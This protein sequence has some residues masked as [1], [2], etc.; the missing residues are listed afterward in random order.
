MPL[1]IDLAYS[2]SAV[3]GV[4]P[5]WLLAGDS[6]A[7]ILDHS[8][9]PYTNEAFLHA[10]SA[11]PKR[12][13]NI[14][15]LTSFQ[16]VTA[17][18]YKVLDAAA[19]LGFLDHVSGK[20]DTNLNQI[21]SKHGLENTA[22]PAWDSVQDALSEAEELAT[23]FVQ[24]KRDMKN[25]KEYSRRYCLSSRPAP[26]EIIRGFIEMVTR[27]PG[28]PAKAEDVIARRR[29]ASALV[30]IDAEARNRKGSER[31]KTAR[32]QSRTPKRK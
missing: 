3:T 6:K 10:R 1:S 24:Q 9:N 11:R 16:R 20:I 7:P 14:A 30:D 25:A 32:L 29:L 5:G 12:A 19:S 28:S 15:F 22:E 26:I 31:P 21:A 27:T 23:M 18:L 8:N 4:S 17:L 13:D 2:I